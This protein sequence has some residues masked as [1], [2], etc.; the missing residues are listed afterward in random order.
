MTRQELLAALTDQFLVDCKASVDRQTAR[1]KGEVA[2]SD[3]EWWERMVGHWKEL[4]AA[5][6]SRMEF[7]KDQTLRER[8]DRNAALG[9]VSAVDLAR[10]QAEMILPSLLKVRADEGAEGPVTEDQLFRASM[11]QSQASIASSLEKIRAAAE[12]ETD[13][14]R[15]RILSTLAGN[16]EID[17]SEMA[18]LGDLSITEERRKQVTEGVV[19]RLRALT[20]VVREPSN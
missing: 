14:K 20:E 4:D 5:A 11:M 3:E 19:S 17:L 7:M 13:P 18:G 12:K 10:S 15:K 1:R 2:L 6:L 16:G 8:R 9:Q